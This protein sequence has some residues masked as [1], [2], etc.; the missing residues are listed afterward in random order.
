MGRR[1]ALLIAT[2]EY[3]DAGLRRL[4]APAH[5]AEALADVLGD[6]RI[7][8]FEVTVLANEP[9]HQ[10]EQA[11]G[12]F[13]RDR[14][15]D[16]LTLLYFTGHGLKDDA[17]RLY[18]AM[19]NTRRDGLWFTGL[20]A[21]DVN[22]AMESCLS[23]QKVLILDCCYSGAYPA[24]RLAK[25]DTAVHTFESFRGRGRTVL[26]AT[27]STQ[28]AFEG[29]QP[30][31]EAARSVFTRYLVE[32]L[33]DGSADLD[34]DGDITVDELYLY[35]HDRVV[36]EMPQQR[37]KK[38][39]NVQG[40]TVVARNVNWTLPPYLRHSVDSPL[41]AVRLAALDEMDRLHRVGNEL[42]RGKVRAEFVRLANDDSRA[43]S[44]AA[45]ARLRSLDPET[46]AIAPAVAVP[47][48]F[49]PPPCRRSSRRPDRPRVP[50]SWRSRQI[51]GRSR[52]R[53][54]RSSGPRRCPAAPGNTC[55]RP[56]GQSRP[57]LPR[58]HISTALPARRAP[59]RRTRHAGPP[60]TES[61]SGDPVPAGLKVTFGQNLCGGPL[62]GKFM[63]CASLSTKNH[64]PLKSTYLSGNP[65]V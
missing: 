27:D 24:G 54:T 32:G 10:V 37:P 50:R 58:R 36:A 48:F 61:P 26:T 29:D 3:Q 44:D 51:R 6:P 41:A 63:S 34:G 22:E 13:Y 39:D 47:P 12:E 19:A 52:T 8:G 46:G 49:F 25:A 11:V 21:E 59:S 4:T 64:A 14:R 53:R 5:D 57:A 40:R 42:V 60:P 20:S 23:Q 65:I 7:A 62:P 55:P 9:H 31:G 28:Y 30:H 15:R 1:L 45:T 16:D 43:V 2:Y 38:Q 17:G 35:V 56:A 33:R 18:L